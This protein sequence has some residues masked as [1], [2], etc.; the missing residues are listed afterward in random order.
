MLSY[1][2]K[3]P[4][5]I[6][7]VVYG[8]CAALIGFLFILLLATHYAYV[9]A[10]AVLERVHRN[11]DLTPMWYGVVRSVDVENRTI[12][13]EAYSRYDIN[14]PRRDVTI[15]V[16]PYA[17]IGHQTL[18]RTE[19]GVHT[20]TALTEAALEDIEPGVRVAIRA[21]PREI[22]NVLTADV[23]LFGNPL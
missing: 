14:E 15:P 6:T 20:L 23:V 5:L 17:F 13:F 3:Y 2:T 11:E 22:D 7:Y 12:V 1:F 16:D 4:R 9:E 21:V 18:T 19:T 10:Q 8:G